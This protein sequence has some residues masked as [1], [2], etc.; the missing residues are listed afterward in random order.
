MFA[1]LGMSPKS[2]NLMYEEAKTLGVISKACDSYS[3]IIIIMIRMHTRD[4]V[5]PAFKHVSHNS[6]Y[7]RCHNKP[8]RVKLTNLPRGWFHVVWTA[9]PGAEIPRIQKT[10]A[11]DNCLH[12][13]IFDRKTKFL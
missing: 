11:G 4:N 2:M 3:M 1:H 8:R 13:A 9:A 7:S 5:I 12:F 10:V 6:R